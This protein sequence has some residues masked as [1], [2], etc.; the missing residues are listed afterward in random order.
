MNIK[1]LVVGESGAGKTHFAGTF[2]K[3]YWIMT[4]PGGK[5]TLDFNADLNKNIVKHCY[6]MPTPL[7]DI[8]DVFADIIVSTKD[9]HKLAAEGKVDTL[10]LDNLT[11]LSENRWIFINKYQKLATS[12]GADDTQRMYGILGRWLYDFIYTNFTT[13]P[14]NVIVTTHIKQEGEEAMKKKANKDT[15]I[16]PNILG[17]FR[18]QA[19]GMFSLVMYLDKIVD[20]QGYKYLARINK[21]N[22]K[23]AKNRYG[24]PSIVNNINYQTILK[25]IEDKK[26]AK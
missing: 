24:L 2:P 11:Y 10:V 5:D 22:G 26:G 18:N 8:K 16:V 23:L 17:G 14:G 4:E 20:G 3:S 13:F 12:S 9:A 21:G 25:A 19:A 7:K 1:A 6:H 15:D